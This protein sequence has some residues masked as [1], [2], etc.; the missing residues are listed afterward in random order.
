MSIGVPSGISIESG[1]SVIVSW[2][3]FLPALGFP[4]CWKFDQY[5]P[6]STMK[7]RFQANNNLKRTKDLRM[8]RGTG[9]RSFGRT[10]S[11]DFFEGTLTSSSAKGDM[12][13]PCF[14]EYY[15][16]L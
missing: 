12:L 13:N 8:P 7:R 14:V 9:Q 1:S 16:R 11:G 5:I 15:C 4:S 2:E 10:F 3:R 6:G